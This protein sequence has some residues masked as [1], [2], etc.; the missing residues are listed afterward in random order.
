MNWER[1]LIKYRREKAAET[2]E[3]ARFLFE[4]GRLFS[5]VNRIYYALFYE[6]SAL[7]MTKNLSSHKHTGIRAL[8]NVH[9]V[10]EGIVETEIGKFYSEMFVFR[11]EGDY[12]DFTFFKE[13]HV[14][15]WLQKAEK[16]LKELEI[17]IDKEITK[18]DNPI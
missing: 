18:M 13:N 6:I 16:Y 3:D 14:N 1:D 5:A 12:K 15:D 7:L 8:F 9:F 2:I 11:Q 4:K 10:K 17:C